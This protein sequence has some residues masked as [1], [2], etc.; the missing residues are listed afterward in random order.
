MNI[1]ELVREMTLEEKASLCSGQDFWHT[2]GLP[3]LGIPPVMVS[4]GPHGLRKQADEAD[5]LGLHN[6]IDAVCFPAACATS[7]SFDRQLMYD[8][9]VVLGKECQAEEV[10]VLLGPAVNI[11]R[12]P[13]CGRNFEYISEDPC[14]AGE[15]AAAYINGVQS[16]GVGTSIKH[17]AANNQE[18]QRM[19]GSS[20]L[21]EQ[22]L[23]EIYFPAFETAVKKAQPWTVMCSYNRINGVYASEDPWLL[24]QVL[25]E[26]WGFKGLVMSDWGAVSD[27]VKGLAAGMDLE[28]P[29]GNGSNDQQIVE[30]VRSGRLP[31]EQLDQAVERIL[32]LVFRHGDNRRKES[33]DREADRQ[34]AADIAR[35]C[36]V[37][38]KNQQ[39]L[40]LK[41]EE[42]VAFIG[43]FAKTPRYQGGGSSHINAHRVTSP[44]SLADVYGTIQYAQG[45]PADRD[46]RISEW[47]KEAL[48]TAEQAE[49]IVVFAGLPDSFESE[50]YD[51]RHMR[52]P[53]CQDQLIQR[54]TALGKPVVVVLQNGSPVE[55]PWAE[56]VQ[57]ILEAYL[58]GETVGEAVMDLLYGKANP[59]GK[60][61]ETFPVKLEDT[62]SYLNFPGIG[63]HT[64]YGE[65]V[66]VGYRYY[67]AK[68]MPVLFPFGHGLSYTTYRYDNLKISRKVC[69]PTEGTTVSLE[70]TNVGRMAGKEVVQLY[71]A[72][73][74]GAVARPVQELKGFAGVF[75]NPGETQTVTMELEPR[76]FEWFDEENGCWRS[77]DGVYQLRIGS[78]SRNI[79]LTGEITRKGNRPPLPVIDEDVQLGELFACEKTA[80]YTQEKLAGFLKAFTG[81]EKEETPDEMML[82]MVKYMPLRALRSFGGLTNRQISEMV[83]DLKKLLI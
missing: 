81:G 35:Q 46:E 9:G 64:R 38:L 57:G 63:H 20:D 12:S 22:A 82:Q 21:S 14:V 80:G 10:S 45:F 44:L 11:K 72:D 73:Q 62:P 42:R 49:K 66:F 32:N 19:Y 23:R 6:S 69:G 16:Q 48:K 39:V 61:A 15:L 18:H 50:G 34:K 83:K 30:A 29:G 70:V 40:P 52:L 74:T 68:K 53:Q 7:A 31:Q 58:G 17:F 67:D 77:N 33:F 51:R 13:L 56:Q 55:M 41:Q 59:C 75:L 71:V 43:G 60:L 54:L 65:G 78:S 3:R 37:L 28:M 36:M 25:R 47:E 27:R 76:A 1:K 24:T 2:Q 8:M 4:D 26:E 79:L 5:H